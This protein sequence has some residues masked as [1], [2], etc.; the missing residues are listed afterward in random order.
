MP[1]IAHKI[2]AFSYT[3]GGLIAA[4]IISNMAPGRSGNFDI[5]REHICENNAEDAYSQ[6]ANMDAK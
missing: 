3:F 4:G 6:E 1:I 5:Q 2:I